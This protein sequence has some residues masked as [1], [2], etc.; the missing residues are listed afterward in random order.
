MGALVGGHEPPAAPIAHLAVTEEVVLRRDGV[1][2]VAAHH[3]RLGQGVLDRVGRIGLLVGQSL[4]DA[5]ALPPGSGQDLG[6]Q[7]AIRCRQ[8][9][10]SESE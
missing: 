4:L 10:G 8:S 2:V 7:M 3:V 6:L 1:R 5:L 9:G